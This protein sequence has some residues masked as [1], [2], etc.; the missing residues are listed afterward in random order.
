MTELGQAKLREMRLESARIEQIARLQMVE[1]FHPEFES[2]QARRDQAAEKRE[3]ILARKQQRKEAAM[4]GQEEEVVVKHSGVH[5]HRV[6]EET[7]QLREELAIFCKERP[8][9]EKL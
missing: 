5:A 3:E 4:Q 9:R 2:S 8:P 7:R 1:T 6:P